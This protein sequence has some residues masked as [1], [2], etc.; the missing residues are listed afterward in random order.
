MKLENEMHRSPAVSCACFRRRAW[1]RARVPE[2]MIDVVAYFLTNR[3]PLK[4]AI[5]ETFGFFT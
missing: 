2:T 5:P 4:K 3:P 1:R